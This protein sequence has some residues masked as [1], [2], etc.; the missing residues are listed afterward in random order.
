MARLPRVTAAEVIRLLA[1]HDFVE[2]RHKGAH[3]IFRN[4]EHRR[5]T[6]AFHTGK[7]LPP[8]TLKNMLN[9]AGWTVEQF[10]KLLKG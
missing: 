6:V 10:V 9:E 2:V 1:R 7:I 3:R 4:A 5:V 8:K